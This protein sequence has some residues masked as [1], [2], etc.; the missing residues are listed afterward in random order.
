[1]ADDPT[2]T[3]LA[4]AEVRDELPQ[5]LD[6]AGYVG[7][8]VFPNNNRR[9]IP[10][11]L[12]LILAAALVATWAATGRGDAV[13]VNGGFLGAAVLLVVFGV[14]H[15]VS[16]Y[17]LDVDERDALVSASRAVGFAVGH[18]WRRSWAGGGCAAARRGASC[19]TRQRTPRPPAGSC[20]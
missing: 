9:R 4:D 17:D 11:Y 20:S 15:L 5:D 19:C 2:P 12:Y 6:A 16:G 3:E 1:M 18:A 10:G 7:P 14:Y 13:L 8:Y